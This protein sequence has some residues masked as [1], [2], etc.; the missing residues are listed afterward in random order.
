[1]SVVR[2]LSSPSGSSACW[3]FLL[4]EPGI[5]RGVLSPVTM[6]SGDEGVTAE[7]HL[8]VG[9]GPT[10]VAVGVPRRMNGAGPARH[11]EERQC[12]KP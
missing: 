2:P 4:K 9:Q 12:G 8:A 3:L 11:V 5:T 1:M 6:F 10:G 7:E